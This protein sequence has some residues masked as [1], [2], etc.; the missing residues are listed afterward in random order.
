MT[1]KHTGK[2]AQFYSLIGLL[3]I[4]VGVMFYTI[5][6]APTPVLASPP[7]VVKQRTIAPIPAT[8]GIPVQVRVPSLGID[9]PVGMG[10]YHPEDSSWTVDASKAYY[11]DA[12][13]PIN[14]S[15]GTTLIYGHA[16]STVF[17]TLPQIQP[18]AEAIVT[19]DTG[20]AFH[21]RLSSSKEVQPNDVSVFTST[22]A[23]T[24]VLQTCIGAYSE[25][26]ALYSFHLVSI[27]TL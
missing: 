12:S 24:L 11:A 27:D 10:T 17:E 5:N 15:N 25:L 7:P 21:Y 26:R 16:Q 23:P 1:L 19:T 14:N 13:M 6:I 8:Q 9:L 3:N 4:A 18:D 20:Y 2:I 22:G